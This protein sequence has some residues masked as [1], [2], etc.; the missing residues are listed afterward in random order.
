MLNTYSGFTYGHTITDE[1]KYIDFDEGAGQL[2]AELSVGSYSLGEFILEVSTAI[3]FAGG[4]E[5][6]VGI[7]RATRILTISSIASFDLLTVTGTNSGVSAYPLMGFT[8]DKLASNTYDGDI[9]SGSFFEPQNMLQSYVDF[10]DMVKTT[11][12]AVSQ[13]ATGQVEV[14][15]Y[16][17][18]E[19]AELNII[20]QT[21]IK[22]GFGSHLKTDLNGIA[23]L[24]AFL[25][26]CTSKAP[27]E[28]VFDIATP[29]VFRKCLLESTTES[30]KGVDYRVN[31]LY[32]SGYANYFESGK[33]VLRGL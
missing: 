20:P 15:S 22:Q 7:D 17:R 12:A 25:D 33:L 14:V 13:T 29:N 2:T 16:G 11:N 30:N 10:I 9:G 32:S 8:V 21:D 1:N 3:N 24:R 27:L 31:E 4:Q 6:T 28:I 23:N 5:Y 18:V 19:F 26:Y